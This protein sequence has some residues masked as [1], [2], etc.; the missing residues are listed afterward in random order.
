MD[1]NTI[2][3]SILEKIFN[4][5][6]PKI[7]GYLRILDI[8]RDSW[9]PNFS[10]LEKEF[11]P[12]THEYIINFYVFMDKEGK[13]QSCTFIKRTDNVG[14]YLSI[15]L[16]EI[17]APPQI[18]NL[19]FQNKKLA[20]K[21]I[22]ENVDI[23]CLIRIGMCAIKEIEYHESPECCSVGSVKKILGLNQNIDLANLE[24]RKILTE[25]IR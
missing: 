8:S 22:C 20:I 18:I 12:P 23:S 19:N 5:L 24:T 13:F 7:I 15:M 4:E 1:S 3:E 6:A 21:E 17:P 9:S 14:G 2:K 16:G 10:M 11:Q 25:F